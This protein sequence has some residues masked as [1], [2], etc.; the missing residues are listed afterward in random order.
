MK[1]IHFS[2]IHTGRLNLHPKALLDKRV[3]GG[4]NYTFRRKKHIRWHYFNRLLEII[5]D[6]KPDMVICTGDFTST[7]TIKEFQ[8]VQRIM[9]P[10]I[11]DQN[12]EFLCVPGNHDYYIHD[13]KS[14]AKRSETFN[15]LNRGKHPIDEFPRC[16]E[17]HGINFLMIDESRPNRSSQS[18]G[19]LRQGDFAKIEQ[20]ISENPDKP[21]I[22]IGHYPLRD[23]D[24]SPLAERRALENG[25]NLYKLLQ[26]GQLDLALCGHI[27]HPYARWEESKSAEFCAGSLTI[28]GK[29]NM[30]IYNEESKTFSQSWINCH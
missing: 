16:H 22:L 29:A 30:I 18:S 4:L 12:F 3:I 13:K 6:E 1:I 25:E 11:E 19:I 20:W 15:Y 5:K 8:E 27:H 24:G 14:F 10:I 7:S 28:S 9:A 26:N 2:D 21:A 17:S 23:Y